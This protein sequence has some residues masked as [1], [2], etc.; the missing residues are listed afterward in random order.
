M[1]CIFCMKRYKRALYINVA[2]F[3]V[4]VPATISGIIL[5]RY[6]PGGRTQAG[7]AV[8]WSLT[9]R[10]WIDVHLWTSLVLVGLIVGHLRLHLTYLEQ[11]PAMLRRR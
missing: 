7:Q 1:S 9:R 4:L 10:T 2:A 8:F 6:L 5:W 3:V 11:V